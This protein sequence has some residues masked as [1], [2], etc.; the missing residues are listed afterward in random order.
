MKCVLILGAILPVLAFLHGS[1]DAFEPAGD[2]PIKPVPFTEVTIRDAFWHPRMAS[3]RKVTIPYDF[4]KCEETGRIDNFAKAAGWMEGEYEGY[5]FNDSDVY[6]VIEGAAYALHLYPDSE[7]DKYLDDLIAKIA[8]AQEEDGYLFT[9][10]T[11]DPENPASGAGDERWSNLRDGHELYCLGHL[12]EAAVAHFRATGKRSLLDVA[13]KGADLVDRIFGPDKIR[14]VPGHQEIEIGLCKLYLVTGEQRYLDLARFFLDERGHARGRELYGSYCQDHEPVVHQTE[15]VG[16]AVRAGYMYS[17]MADVAALTSDEDYVTAIDRIWQNV[18]S[19]KLYLTGGIGSRASGEAFGEDYELPNATAYNET[20]AAIANAM[21]NHRLFLLHG[22]ARYVDVLER[23]IYNGFL[24]GVSLSG[25]SFFYPNPLASFGKH[26]RSPW[27]GC[28][29]CPTN[30]VRFLPSL[31]GY[32]YAFKGKE[33][34]VNLFIGGGGFVPLEDNRVGLF[35]ETRYPWDGRISIGVDPQ[36]AME[37]CVN[38]RIPGWARNQPVPSD[39][40][41]FKDPGEEAISLEINGET[42]P[43]EM[44]N[45][46]ARILRKWKKGD[47]IELVLP[48][49]VERVLSHPSVKADAGRVALSRGPLV[50]CAEWPDNGGHVSNLVLPDEA[51]LAVEYRKD[52]LGGICVIRGKAQA[53]FRS[54]DRDQVERKEHDLVAIPYYAWAHRGKG[55]MAV[56]LA[57]ED[58]LVR[59]LP[60]PTPAVAARVQASHT[61]RGDSREAV[62]D[63]YE[64]A[65]SSDHGIPRFTWWDHK[66]GVEWIQYD[67]DE[68]VELSSL[69]VYWFDDTGTGGCRVPESWQALYLEGGQWI[70]VKGAGTFGKEKDR[71]NEVAFE[72]MKTRSLRLEVKLQAGFSGGILEWRVE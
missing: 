20:C 2:Y 14:D 27:F 26:S 50:Y 66:G 24:S 5:R 60:A 53:L 17:G 69:E 52:L 33:I 70:P 42:Q 72:P 23:I 28:S 22:D 46:F 31:P 54:K 41:H 7:L 44:H 35:Q 51:E 29:C 61:C 71:F 49:P 18:I 64:P 8:A 6:K 1:A 55:E 38:V 13:V 40:Y 62:N 58:G 9:T 19:K 57:R 68:E 67:F 56:W 36:K 11:I 65:S 15:P 30:V 63:L 12:F 32:V 43:L 3:N 39:L 21:W 45:G 48:M 25:D 4:K 47:T 10:R 34:Y 37:F 16:H 59:A